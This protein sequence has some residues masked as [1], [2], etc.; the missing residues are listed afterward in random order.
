MLNHLNNTEECMQ[1]SIKY[2]IP[3]DICGN[4]IIMD[5]PIFYI[6]EDGHV[7]DKLKN[8]FVSKIERSM[9]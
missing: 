2:P 4:P 7:R 1:L 6:C 3:C 9:Q 8:K 5:S